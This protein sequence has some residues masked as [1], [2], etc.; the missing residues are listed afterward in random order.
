M[1]RAVFHAPM[2]ALNADAQLNARYPTAQG[3][4]ICLGFHPFI[5][6]TGASVC[7]R[8]LLSMRLIDC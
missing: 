8:V 3:S 6:D 2:F 5:A 4:Q 1:A 7:L